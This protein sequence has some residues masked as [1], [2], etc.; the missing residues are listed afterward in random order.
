VDFGEIQILPLSNI[1]SSMAMPVRYIKRA[2]EKNLVP[3]PREDE[4]VKIN[5]TI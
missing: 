1:G 4:D 2:R 3:V 5:E